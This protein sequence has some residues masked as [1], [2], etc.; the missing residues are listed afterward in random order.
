MSFPPPPPPDDATI[1]LLLPR[2]QGAAS[3]T[4]QASPPL[5]RLGERREELPGVPS[6]CPPPSWHCRGHDFRKEFLRLGE[7][8]EA[9]PGVP[10]M[11]LTATATPRV[12]AE[13]SR[14]LRL[15]PG[16]MT[17]T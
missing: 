1:S 17:R 13:I 8:R 11:A 9:L 14:Q 5:L 3:H 4:P 15:R 16:D 7:L 12:Q 2:P 6:W 10:V